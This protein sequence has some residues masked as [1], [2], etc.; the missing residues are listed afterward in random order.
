MLA[1]ITLF[2]SVISFCPSLKSSSLAEI[3]AS[4]RDRVGAVANFQREK[5]LPQN[6]ESIIKL[7]K[8]NLFQI[9]RG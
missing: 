9:V 1:E 2:C 8:G 5:A 6:K 3:S 4:V 7:G